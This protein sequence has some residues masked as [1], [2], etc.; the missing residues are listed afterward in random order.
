MPRFIYPVR[1]LTKTLHSREITQGTHKAFAK[2]LLNND[3]SCLNIFINHLIEELAVNSSTLQLTAL[4]KTLFLLEARC[5]SISPVIDFTKK[6]KDKQYNYT[7]NI[8]DTIDLM[9]KQ[10]FEK[11]IY[12]DKG[13]YCEV[14]L[15]KQF[16][17]ENI[18][19]IF[20]DSLDILVVKDKKIN[21][22]N[23]TLDEKKEIALKLP[24]T[25]FTS[26]IKYVES[27]DQKVRKTNILKL[28]KSF[29]EEPYNLSVY[30]TGLFSI[31]SIC[32]Y[33]DLASIHNNEYHL[34]KNYGFSMEQI[35]NTPPSELSLYYSFIEEEAKKAKAEQ[36]AAKQTNNLTPATFANQS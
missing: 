7:I 15:P 8:N 6:E 20:C 34:I 25:I 36:D 13:I 35:N 33:L 5:F 32:F 19:D 27:Q 11:F 17:Y 9:L 22:D 23:F 26:Y 21:L 10:T 1:T 12:N 29:S 18:E 2:M 3:A 14:S 24:D 4:D 30:G 28:P 16:F 31:L